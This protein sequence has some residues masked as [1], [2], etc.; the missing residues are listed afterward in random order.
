MKTLILAMCATSIALAAPVPKE[1]KRDDLGRIEGEWW[2]ARFNNNVNPD[3]ATARR[4]RFNRD[5]SAGIYG[6]VDAEP[7]RYEFAIDQSTA[8]PSFTWNSKIGRENYIGSYRIEGDTLFIVFTD[9]AK[10]IAKEVKPGAGDCYYE[11][12]RVK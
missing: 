5:G 10:P 7:R 9:A 11:L 8:P 1:A 3:A 2:E 6:R 4:F 12:K